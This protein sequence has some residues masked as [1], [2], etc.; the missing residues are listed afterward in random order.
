MM[1]IYGIIYKTENLINGKTY[2]G[3]T[4]L[5]KK[6]FDSYLGSG[7]I[8]HRAIEKYGINNFKRYTL[9]ECISK[10]QLN[11][12]ERLF[13]KMLKPDYNIAEGGHGG[14]TS[15]FKSEEEKK[16][17]SEKLKS[18]WDA[19]SEEE[20][21]Q[22]NEKLSNSLLNRTEEEKVKT[23][24]KRL[25]TLENR[26][27]EEKMKTAEKRHNTWVN[28][29]EEEMLERSQKISF[30]VSGDKN[31][32]KRKEVREKISNTLFGRALSEDHK[33]AI[34]EG[35]EGRVQSE[36]MKQT[37]SISNRETYMK[38]GTFIVAIEIESG[39]TQTFYSRREAQRELKLKRIPSISMNESKQVRKRKY[40]FRLA[41]E[42]EKENY[43]INYYNNIEEK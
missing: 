22:R 17:T 37:C 14:N 38:K 31:P 3:Q 11:R 42:Q 21:K 25:Q 28:K 40:N 30:H 9:C 15:Y 39:K 13:I 34:S 12:M 7:L 6:D 29:P 5:D 2:I 32:S 16:Q 35:L 20:K 26:T 43:I 27:D 24:E 18:I 23:S 10:D 4:I 19:K 1:P 8:L 41:T 33:K 36:Q